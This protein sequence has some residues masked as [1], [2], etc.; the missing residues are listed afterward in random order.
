MWVELEPIRLWQ[1]LLCVR[2][3]TQ[4]LIHIAIT[5]EA[6]DAICATLPLGS[7]MYEAESNAKGDRLVWIEA[8]VVDQLAAL[9]GPGESYSDVILRLAEAERRD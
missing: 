8:A 6:F 9:R 1:R 4:T 7:V 2:N 3:E 5:P